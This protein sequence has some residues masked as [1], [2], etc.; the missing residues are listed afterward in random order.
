MLVEFHKG[1]IMEGENTYTKRKHFWG[2]PESKRQKIYLCTGVKGI[3]DESEVDQ[4]IERLTQEELK[5]DGWG[6]DF[7]GWQR[8]VPLEERTELAKKLKWD[9]EELPTYQVK[10]ELI[11]SWTMEKILKTLTG[12]QF[13]QFCKSNEISFKEDKLHV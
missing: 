6:T 4:E 11:N 12:E 8:V 13:V 5:E 2:K 9:L 7:S 1:F 10:T 3:C